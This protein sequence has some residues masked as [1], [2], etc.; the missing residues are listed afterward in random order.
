VAIGGA[1]LVALAVILIVVFAL[2]GSAA[3]KTSSSA[4]GASHARAVRSG[5]RS[6]LSVAV[7]NATETNG[8]AHRVSN[9]LQR[10]GYSR[11]T[12]LG[13]RPP[14]ADQLTVV[15][16]ATGHKSDAEA[17]A[18]S[19]GVSHTAPLESGVASLAGSAS[20]VVVVGLDKATSGA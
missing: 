2:G 12:P 5:H 6:H 20:V 9:Q 18:H 14:G 10:S 8:L 7:L 11:A 16:Y 19:L 17:V 13:G 4:S 3:H 1:A 15:E